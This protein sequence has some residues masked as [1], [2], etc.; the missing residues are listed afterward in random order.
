MKTGEQYIFLIPVP[1]FNVWL[2]AASIPDQPFTVQI[3]WSCYG[4]LV[5]MLIISNYIN[6]T[7]RPER[8]SVCEL[9]IVMWCGG[10]NMTNAEHR[11]A[12]RRRLGE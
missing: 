10:K 7:Q 6:S 4:N 11:E 9:A 8:N 5:A 2:L 3:M 12:M 1:N